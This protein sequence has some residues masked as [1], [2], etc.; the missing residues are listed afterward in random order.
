MICE[1]WRDC[2]RLNLIISDK[3]CDSHLI[4]NLPSVANLISTKLGGRE[5]WDKDE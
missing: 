2:V 3:V 4:A 5:N 1:Y